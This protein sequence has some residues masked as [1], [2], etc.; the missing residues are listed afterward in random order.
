MK[1]ELTAIF[2]FF[3]I[4]LTAVSLYSYHAA[5]PC[6]GNNALSLPDNVQNLFG[7]VGAHVAGFFVY[8]F[9]IGA[10]WIPLILSLISVWYLKGKGRKIV[11]LTLIGGFMLT[12]S[13]G[14]IFFSVQ[15]GL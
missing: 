11:W 14:S 12:V 1:K 3:L 4:V 8:L 10:L 13:T 6:V 7:L 9:G 5:D 15:R 2:L